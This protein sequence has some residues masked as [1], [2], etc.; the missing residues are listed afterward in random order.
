M[1]KL[2]EIGCDPDCGF[3][4]RSHEKSEVVKM[5]IEHMKDIHDKE[6]SEEEAAD[7]VKTV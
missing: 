3:M 1:K 6:V 2:Y 7:M 5:G 4:V